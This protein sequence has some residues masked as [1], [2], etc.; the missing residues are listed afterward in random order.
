MPTRQTSSS[1]KPKSPRIQVVLPEDLCARLTAMAELESRTVSNMARVLI[2]Q[3]VQ[4]HEQELEAS[5][6]APSREERLR[7][8]LESQPPRRLRGAPRRLR[9][10]RPG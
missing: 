9:L 7:S 8:A 6:P 4:R 1:G 10:H 2:Q 3:G 5:I